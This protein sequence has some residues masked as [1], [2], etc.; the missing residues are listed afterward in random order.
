MADAAAV[1]A[2]KRQKV[3][4]EDDNNGAAAAAK[5]SAAAPGTAAAGMNTLMQGWYS[6]LSSMWP[7]QAMCLQVQ[8]VLH[9][10]KSKFQDVMVFQSESYGKVLVLDGAIQLTERD[11]FAYQEMIAHL[12]LCSIKNPKKVL[13][14]GGGDGGVIREVARH[15]SIEQ[16]D[17]CEIDEMVID[18]SKKYF[19]KVAVGFEDPR[20]RVHVMDGIKFVEDAQPGTYDAI[21]VDSSDPVG[22]AKVL[23]EQPFYRAMARALR[24]GGI[25]CTQA[26]CTWLH[27]DLI[28]ELTAD[29]AAIFKG[30]VQYAYTTIP[31]YPSGQIGFLLCATEGGEAGVH[32]FRTPVTSLPAKPASPVSIPPLKYYNPRVHSAAFVLPQFAHEALAPYLIE[33]S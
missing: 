7:G 32:D 9:E 27:L 16:I 25:V 3:G 21:I 22:P 15:D 12:P 2:A 23:Y 28:K 5:Y 8:E 14:V 26:E 1:D 31:T 11:E 20:V 13:V 19:P 4:G 18:V 17:L 6:E 24:P 10:G 33:P 29:A 30:G